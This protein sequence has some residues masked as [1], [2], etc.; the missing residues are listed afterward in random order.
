MRRVVLEPAAERR[1]RHLRRARS[2]AA[3][4]GSTSG[5][6]PRAACG[7][8]GSRRSC[9]RVIHAGSSSVADP[10]VVAH[11]AAVFRLQVVG[12]VLHPHE[13]ARRLL[14]R[15]SW[16]TYVR[17]RAASSARPRCRA[18]CA[19]GCGTRGTRPARRRRSTAP[20]CRRRCG[21]GRGSRRRRAAASHERRRQ[22]VGETDP[23]A[24]VRVDEHAASEAD[25]DREVRRAT[26][27][28]PLRCRRV[29]RLALAGATEPTGMARGEQRRP[30]QS[31]RAAAFATPPG[32]RRGGR[33]C[34]RAD[35]PARAS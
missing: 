22:P 21:A 32:R 16:R 23:V 15:C 11:D 26:G 17:I 35:A 20:R 14:P 27:R 34:R 33:T 6:T 13:V 24:A 30:Q 19:R 5:P 10:H 3:G 18:R 25:R 1:A 2:S 29:P 31:S 4:P 12:A 9:R 8:G 28:W 7:C